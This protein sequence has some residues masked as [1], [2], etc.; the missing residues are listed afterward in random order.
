MK[1]VI[2]RH[3]K[4]LFVILVASWIFFRYVVPAAQNNK[5]AVELTKRNNQ[6]SVVSESKSSSESLGENN[7][8]WLIGNNQIVFQWK[9]PPPGSDSSDIVTIK[10]TDYPELFS[11][12]DYN[13][14]KVTPFKVGESILYLIS[15]VYYQAA[16]Y[17]LHHA[18]V[19]DIWRNGAV[20]YETNQYNIQGAFHTLSVAGN[21][22]LV[23]TFLYGSYDY[24]RSC[25]YLLKEFL[26]FV[27]HKG[28]ISSNVAH[29]KE[30]E[31]MLA[32]VEKNNHCA[33]VA[34]GRQVT[35][36]DIKK[37]YGE[38]YRC[39]S[40]QKD[41]KMSGTSPKEYFALKAKITKILSGEE[42]SL[43]NNDL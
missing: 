26:A 20:Q 6:N 15:N 22:E 9:T 16:G 33:A 31:E 38:N 11:N 42:V 17:T 5:Q 39:Q 35:F 14:I 18:I 21:A 32:N 2:K 4:F 29:K 40:S 41:M 10:A 23:S 37:Q 36:E 7:I 34:G 30:F 1:K 24:C 27:P 3:W 12:L 19:V 43:L 13:V 28:F 25:G 8:T